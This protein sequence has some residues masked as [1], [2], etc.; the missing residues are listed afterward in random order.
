MQSV[1]DAAAH[2]EQLLDVPALLK[3]RI[4]DAVALRKALM[5]PSGDTTVYRL[6]NR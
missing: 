1:A 5:L 3:A 4:A 6:I 2:P